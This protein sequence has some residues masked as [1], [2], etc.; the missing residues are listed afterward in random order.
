VKP[1]VRLE[2]NNMIFET[3]SSVKEVE[4]TKECFQNKKYKSFVTGYLDDF[5]T[6]FYSPFLLGFTVGLI[7]IVPLAADIVTVSPAWKYEGNYGSY[8]TTNITNENILTI[9]NKDSLSG[10]LKIINLND[11]SLKEHNFNSELLPIKINFKNTNGKGA[12][13]QI[14]S[15]INNNRY[16]SF[17]IK[18]DMYID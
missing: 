14:D 8:C 7:L 13:L 9:K 11:N 10:Q 1:Q 17:K 4:H 5:N 3:I 16:D 6:T 12:L 18:K 2:N 15:T